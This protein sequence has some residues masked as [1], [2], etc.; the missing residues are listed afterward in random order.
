MIINNLLIAIFL[1]AIGIVIWLKLL[2]SKL[3]Y[4]LE[5]LERKKRR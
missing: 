1:S 2:N 4:I 3:N 5:V